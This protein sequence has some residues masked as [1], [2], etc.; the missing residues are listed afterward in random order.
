LDHSKNLSLLEDTG[1]NAWPG[2][3]IKVRR[4]VNASLR[5]VLSCL[6]ALSQKRNT[7]TMKV[8]GQEEFVSG[9]EGTIFG[10]EGTIF[11]SRRD[12]FGVKNGLFLG[13]KRT[14]SGSRTD[15]FR[16]KN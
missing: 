10:H 12:Y 14:L 7:P 8:L 16:V 4:D 11:G 2:N 13:Q 1:K 5:S 9:H 6:P 15:Y 3:L